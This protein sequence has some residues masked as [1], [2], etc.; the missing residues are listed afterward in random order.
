MAST[1][2]YSLL[3]LNG[4]FRFRQV[5]KSTDVTAISRYGWRVPVLGR[6][7]DWIV[8]LFL[9]REAIVRHMHEEGRYMKTAIE[10]KGCGNP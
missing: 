5:D 1:F 9:K 4:E 2:P 6:L 3:N 8:S 10:D 7:I